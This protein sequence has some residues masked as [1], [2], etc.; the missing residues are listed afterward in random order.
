MDCAERMM[1]ILKNIS[2]KIILVKSKLIEMKELGWKVP[3][4]VIDCL[5]PLNM[6]A[7]NAAGFDSH[8][9]IDAIRKMNPDTW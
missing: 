4:K 8:F 9:I 3:K 2:D 6:M 5:V 1:E 7:Y